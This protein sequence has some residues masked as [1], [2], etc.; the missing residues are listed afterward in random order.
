MAQQSVV[1]PSIGTSSQGRQSAAHDV[2][3]VTS[4]DGLFVIRPRVVLADDA[5]QTHV[6]TVKDG[7]LY[8]RDPA[9]LALVQ[10]LV[11]GQREMSRLMNALLTSVGST[12]ATL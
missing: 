12:E 11:D 7:Y 5:D 3:K 6:A 2:S 4:P 1:P 8:A 10:Q 9:L